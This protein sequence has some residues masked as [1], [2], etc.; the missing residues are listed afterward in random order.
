MTS[1]KQHLSSV[2]DFLL[3]MKTKYKTQDRIAEYA[4]FLLHYPQGKR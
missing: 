2:H 4:I 1:M 3:H